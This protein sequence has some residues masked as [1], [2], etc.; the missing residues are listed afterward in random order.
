V[1]PNWYLQFFVHRWQKVKGLT[2]IL[3]GSRYEVDDIELDWAYKPDTFDFIHARNLGQSIDDWPRMLQ[4]AFTC[5]KPGGYIELA[6]NGGE[7]S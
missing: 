6:E 2:D 4:Q 3:L 7:L 1:P 5:L